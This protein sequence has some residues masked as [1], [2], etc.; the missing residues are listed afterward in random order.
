MSSIG[1]LIKKIVTIY[2]KEEKQCS[3]EINKF[4]D[5]HLKI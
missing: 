4:L 3:D 5:S 2:G 1:D